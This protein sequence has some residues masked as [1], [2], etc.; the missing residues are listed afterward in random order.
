M[1]RPAGTSVGSLPHSAGTHE[2][3][4]EIRLSDDDAHRGGLYAT[5]V[6]ARPEQRAMNRTAHREANPSVELPLQ[7]GSPR[8][9]S[10][11]EP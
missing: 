5:H 7:P 4:L 9:G 1:T 6:V 10:R 3:S 11:A 2:S 8:P